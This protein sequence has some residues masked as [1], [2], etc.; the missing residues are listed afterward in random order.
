MGPFARISHVFTDVGTSWKTESVSSPIKYRV[1][2][3][4]AYPT[5][6][7]TQVAF[8]LQEETTSAIKASVE[9]VY[10]ALEYDLT[11]D[12]LD[13]VESDD[14]IIVN[15]RRRTSQN[16]GTSYLSVRCDSTGNT[17]NVE[18]DVEVIT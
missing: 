5:G 3:V 2:R 12:F 8:R 9:G 6:S 17:V 7:A 4:R 13:A 1:V 14:E 18:M 16:Q 10:T 15:P 11:T